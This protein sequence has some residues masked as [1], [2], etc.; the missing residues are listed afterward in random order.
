MIAVSRAAAA[1]LLL[2][3]L[4]GCASTPEPSPTE[5]F[6]TETRVAFDSGWTDQQL[7]SLAGIAC[8]APGGE[9]DRITSLMAERDV[10]DY[11]QA[12]TVT[13]AAQRHI[14]AS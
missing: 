3:A 7:I 10:L 8:A 5:R 9:S 12:S 1:A 14:C 6:L 11:R 2:A 13:G 4:G